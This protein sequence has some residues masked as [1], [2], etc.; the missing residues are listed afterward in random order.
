ML[1]LFPSSETR[2]LLNPRLERRNLT[3]SSP[4]LPGNARQLLNFWLRVQEAKKTVYKPKRLSP[5]GPDP[6]HH[7]DNA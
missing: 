3:S 1:L 2:R 7:D 4:S 6:R 5:G